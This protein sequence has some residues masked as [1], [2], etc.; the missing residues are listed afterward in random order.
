MLIAQTGRLPA[1]AGRM[2]EKRRPHPV[3]QAAGAFC[4]SWTRLQ[5]HIHVCSLDGLGLIKSKASF[6]RPAERPPNSPRPQPISLGVRASL[7]LCALLYFSAPIGV[8]LMPDGLREMKLHFCSREGQTD[9]F[10]D[11]LSRVGIKTYCLTDA[12]ERHWFCHIGN[13]QFVNNC[14]KEPSQKSLGNPNLPASCSC[15]RIVNIFFVG[16]FK[17]FKVCLNIRKTPRVKRH[18]KWTTLANKRM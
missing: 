13:G 1:A 4:P 16:R 14:F 15:W 12:H 18:S 8:R 3:A 7:P 9:A 17:H 11:I 5:A 2:P 6:M 10:C